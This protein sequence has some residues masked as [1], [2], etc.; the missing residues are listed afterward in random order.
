VL[1]VPT[2]RWADAPADLLHLAATDLDSGCTP[3]PT[4][5]AFRGDDALALVG[6]RPFERD[7]LLQALLEVLALLLPLGADR[8]GLAL[9]GRAWRLDDPIVPVVGDV[10]LRSPVL[11][12][13]L[14]DGHDGPSTASSSV[15]PVHVDDDGWRWLGTL[16]TGDEAPEAPVI[17]ALRR[18]VDARHDVVRTST[19]D[20]LGLQ[21]G[22]ILL[23]GHVLLLTPLAAEQLEE[24]VAA[25]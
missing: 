23:R 2:L 8:L 13:T 24:R 16:D 14:V 6:L 9:T 3:A 5:V 12:L 10:D 21:F 22:R 18:L 1:P 4:L 25:F 17:D 15:H 19:S 11:I 7:E 20:E